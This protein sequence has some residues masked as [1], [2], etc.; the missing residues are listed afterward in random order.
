MK[1]CGV[2]SS[3]TVMCGEETINYTYLLL[4]QEY[5][6]FGVKV[7]PYFFLHARVNSTTIPSFPFFM[8]QYSHTSKISSN[9]LDK[10]CD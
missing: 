3:T 4:F 9:F 8:L 6:I 1:Y 2:R 7:T 5:H 10:K